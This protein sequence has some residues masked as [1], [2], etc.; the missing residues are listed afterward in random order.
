M[1][2]EQN[3]G[4]NLSQQAE[5]AATEDTTNQPHDDGIVVDNG[6]AIV[7]EAKK[8]ELEAEQAKKDAEAAEAEKVKKQKPG[9]WE[10]QLERERAE[11][12]EMAARLEKLEKLVSGKSDPAEDAPPK[13]EDFENVL[14]F[15]KAERDYELEKF[16]K[17]LAEERN[18]T[19]EVSKQQ[20]E[21]EKKLQA[22][23]LREAKI[24]AENPDY[25]ENLTEL[26]EAG[27][28]T[29]PMIEVIYDSDIGEK[30]ALHLTKNPDEAALISTLSG[31]QLYRVMGMLEARLTSG[32]QSQENT[33]VRQTKAAP[34]INPVKIQSKSQKDPKDMDQREYEEW[35]Y[36]GRKK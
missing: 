4:V 33:G 34:P 5:V 8:S 25:I 2:I 6:G 32:N 28:I 18:K 9:K 11:K 22:Y 29:Q 15:I 31:P 30:I 13:I 1:T 12:A 14:D 3:A 35:L 17:S 10:R 19:D 20:V 21:F 16:K 7:N 27:H 23:D 36:S 24:I 26:A